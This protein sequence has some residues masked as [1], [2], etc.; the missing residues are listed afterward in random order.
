MNLKGL[1]PG[2]SYKYLVTMEGL[3][4]RAE[5]IPGSG[6]DKRGGLDGGE[7]VG[8]DHLYLT[9]VWCG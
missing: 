5:Q 2:K 9:T 1:V 4:G 8:L 3:N 6:N 7:M